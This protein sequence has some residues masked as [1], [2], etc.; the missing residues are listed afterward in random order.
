MAGRDW[1]RGWIT[2]YRGESPPLSSVVGA[3]TPQRRILAATAQ[4]LLGV[5]YLIMAQS[6]QGLLPSVG[7]S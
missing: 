7:L 6:C 1:E 2:A 4:V 5:A 3:V